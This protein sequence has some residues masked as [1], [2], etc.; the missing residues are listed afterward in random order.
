MLLSTRAVA[1]R[2]FA[3]LLLAVV[4]AVPT[5]ANALELVYFD[6]DWCAPCR[7]FKKEVLPGWK[8]SELG[9][10]IELRMAE[11]KDQTRL[12]IGF[13][14]KIVEVPVFVLVENG[15][16]VGRVVG[17][18]TARKF[19]AELREALDQQASEQR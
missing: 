6:A 11:M 5:R 16:E 2:L 3:S 1:A 15:V 9:A 8:E 4:I 13:A 19:W 18:T 12:G 14:E 10:R 7:K 17:Y